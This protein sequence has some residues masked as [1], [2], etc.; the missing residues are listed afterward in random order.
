MLKDE[1]K[2]QIDIIIDAYND[3]LDAGKNH[4]LNENPFPEGTKENYA[5]NEGE[6]AGFGRLENYRDN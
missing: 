5:W 4:N 6:T 1:D 2:K 3:G